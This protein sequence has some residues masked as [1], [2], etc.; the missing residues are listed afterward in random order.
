[1][2]PWQ[3]RPQLVRVDDSLYEQEAA[4]S[5]ANLGET[6]GAVALVQRLDYRVHDGRRAAHAEDHFLQLKRR[7]L[8]ATRT[9]QA[10]LALIC[11]GPGLLEQH[12]F[13]DTTPGIIIAR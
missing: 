8:L 7:I 5:L 12:R 2:A 1:M 6:N 10:P 13:I 9:D 4:P 11:P 3:G